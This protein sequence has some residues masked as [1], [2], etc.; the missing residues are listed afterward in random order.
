MKR[1]K[2][3]KWAGFLILCMVLFF[4]TSPL[5]LAEQGKTEKKCF[6]INNKPSELPFSPAVMVRDTLYISG[7]LAINPNT[8]KFE[9]GSMTKQA[10]MV[11]RNIE[12]L[13]RKADMFLIN[14]VQTT[15]YISDFKEFEEFNK[16]YKKW[17]PK[18]PPTR[19]TV[20]VSKLA[21]NA[22]IE[23]SAIAIK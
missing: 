7:Q 10:N 14:V 15:V 11:L 20:Q 9:G 19:A 23:I 3:K 13:L 12:L 1:L 17:F 18:K 6:Y 8:G 2:F 5:I 22:K 16:V 21:R 4:L